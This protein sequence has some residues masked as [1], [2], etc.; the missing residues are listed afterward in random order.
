M[1]DAANPDRQTKP[2]ENKVGF[3]SIGTVA[4][5]LV[6]EKEAGAKYNVGSG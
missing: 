4:S 5:I 2:S 1:T 3:S 6:L